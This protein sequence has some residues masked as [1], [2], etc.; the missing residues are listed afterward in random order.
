[1]ATKETTNSKD[2]APETNKDQTNETTA[3]QDATFKPWPVIM[4]VANK[5]RPYNPRRFQKG[6]F[7]S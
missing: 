6:I 1:M 5:R 2:T 3:S 4:R 7:Y